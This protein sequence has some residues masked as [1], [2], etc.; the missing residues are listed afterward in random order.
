ME[1]K[2]GQKYSD[3]CDRSIVII[4]NI[5]IGVQRRYI[6]YYDINNPNP[7]YCYFVTDESLFLNYHTLFTPFRP[8]W[9]LDDSTKIYAD[10]VDTENYLYDVDSM[11]FKTNICHPE[12][13][14]YQYKNR[15]SDFGILFKDGSHMWARWIGEDND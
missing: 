8:H 3:K 4:S 15:E 13:R 10:E 9:L 12:Y 5:F 14:P 2:V 1:I 7:S 6:E 11:F